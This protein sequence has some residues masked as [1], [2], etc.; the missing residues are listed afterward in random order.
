MGANAAN[1]HVVAVIHKVLGGNGCR[2]LAALMLLHEVR[3]ICGGNV[4]KDHLKRWKR[5][6]C[7]GKHSL[8]EDF[9]PVKNINIRVGHFAMNQQ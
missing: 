5:V 4:F 2:K 6:Q 9:F 3:G 7:R 1:Q 8:Q